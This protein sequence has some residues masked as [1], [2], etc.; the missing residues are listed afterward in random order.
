LVVLLATLALAGI[1]IVETS[2]WSR[3][4]QRL[5]PRVLADSAGVTS[6]V[7][8]E[9][10]AVDVSPQAA[11]TAGSAAPPAAEALVPA[12]AP[13]LVGASVDGAFDVDSSGHFVPTAS[14]VRLFD[15]FLAAEGEIPARDL[16]RSVQREAE[17]AL[18]P[19]E[20]DNAMALF[21]RYVEYRP[22]AA[23]SLAG[24]AKGDYRGALAAMH[25]V[26]EESFGAQD[27]QRMFGEAE[28]IAMVTMNEAEVEASDLPA[29]ERARRMAAQAESL[30]PWLR[31]IHARRARDAEEVA[32]A[33]QGVGVPRR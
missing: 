17:R 20:V 14:A 11:A 13:S 22:R 19:A 28:T 15:F 2:P 26:R 9:T 7:Q 8:M 31:A 32:A 21:E 10:P 6:A 3:E 25:R 27:A 33:T 16:W 30:P 5:R 29:D 12:L 24:V 4:T 18:S 1:A 23:A